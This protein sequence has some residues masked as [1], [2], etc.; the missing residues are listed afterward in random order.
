MGFFLEVFYRLSI[1]I[2]AGMILFFL[3][4][5]LLKWL[6]KRDLFRW[7]MRKTGKE[8]HK[9][10]VKG[11]IHPRGDLR[12]YEMEFEIE[13]PYKSISQPAMELD[14]SDELIF[15]AVNKK[16]GKLYNTR[17]YYLNNVNPKSITYYEED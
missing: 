5:P 14:K 9:V 7:V 15:N 2:L 13:L 6:Y 8:K 12:N 11:R 3:K 16:Y 17:D 10:I 4:K 1:L